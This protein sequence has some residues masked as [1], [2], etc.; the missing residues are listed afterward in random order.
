MVPDT[1]SNPQ[2]PQLLNPVDKD[3]VMQTL[4]VYSESGGVTKTSTAVSLA[5]VAARG[6]RRV[7]LIDLDPR[8]ATTKWTPVE[9]KQP[10]HDIGAILATDDCRGY[11]DA[12][13]IDVPA[14]TENLK[15]VPASRN[16]SLR[17]AENADGAEYRLLTALEGHD[18]DLVVIDCPNRQGGPLIRGALMA[19]DSIVY[20]S[21]LS[22]D[23]VDGVTGARQTV[24][25]FRRNL[26]RIGAAQRPEEVGI[27][28][29][30]ITDNLV[31][32]PLVE[33]AAAEDLGATGLLL[34]PMVP[35]R[36]IVEQVRLTG[37]WYGDYPSGRKVLEAYTELAGKVIG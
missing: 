20:A 36:T 8:G 22:G 10:G 24:S 33:R 32:Q 4:A 2:F 19:A 28:A 7:T 37:E 35:K 3:V 6:G 17:E 5:V 14:W 21:K 12:L 16:V 31:A 27:I 23:G 15:I 11:A 25:A 13:A 26:A 30:A 1:P 34:T 9:P 18:A 29:A